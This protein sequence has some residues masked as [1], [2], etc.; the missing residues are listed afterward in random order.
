MEQ[1]AIRERE[2]KGGKRGR[3]GR[4]KGMEGR[5]TCGFFVKIGF[6][7]DAAATHRLPPLL[8]GTFLYFCFLEHMFR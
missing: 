3:E 2:G 1:E 5:R 8:A 7:F 4:R 6:V